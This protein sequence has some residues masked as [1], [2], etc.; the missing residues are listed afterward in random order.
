MGEAVWI[1]IIVCLILYFIPY[2]IASTREHHNKM[3]IFWLNLLAGWTLLGWFGAFI[4]ALTA[5]K[6]QLKPAE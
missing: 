3:A 2:W 1:I 4:W 6:P 5:V